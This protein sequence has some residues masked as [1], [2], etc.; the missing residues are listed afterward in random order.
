MH[1]R[2]VESIKLASTAP[3]KYRCIERK[4]KED[5][6]ESLPMGAHFDISLRAQPTKCE[7]RD[8]R[9]FNRTL[10]F[11][12]ATVPHSFNLNQQRRRLSILHNV[13]ILI[14]RRIH[15]IATRKSVDIYI[16]RGQDIWRAYTTK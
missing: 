7:A 2:R 14:H 1:Q 16:G 6:L 11:R 12:A 8:S 10:T 13:G 5:R 15:T 3:L 9:Y 4:K